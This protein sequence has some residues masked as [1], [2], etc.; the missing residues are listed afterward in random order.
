M[1]G[2]V[3]PFIVDRPLMSR[4]PSLDASPP[5]SPDDLREGES[6]EPGIYSGCLSPACR[7]CRCGISKAKNLP[8]PA[9][10]PG[11]FFGAPPSDALYNEAL[12]HC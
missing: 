2:G 4:L 1:I 3:M 8:E 11:D 6:R 12:V 7:H 5:Y 10:K 9:D